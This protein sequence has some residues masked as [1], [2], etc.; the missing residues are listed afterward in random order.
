[1]CIHI[2]TIQVTPLKSIKGEQPDNDTEQ[3]DG[4]EN[5]HEGEPKEQDKLEEETVHRT[6]MFNWE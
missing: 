6:G 3:D 2:L 1:M 4:I 5:D